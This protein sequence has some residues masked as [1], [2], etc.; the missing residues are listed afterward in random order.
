MTK[1]I[2]GA[3]YETFGVNGNES[4]GQILASLGVDCLVLGA[5]GDGNSVTT[6]GLLAGIPSAADVLGGAIREGA[7]KF[8]RVTSPS[9]LIKVVKNGG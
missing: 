2:Y 3:Y 8:K 9:R 4:T 5:V 6:D 7:S 1:S